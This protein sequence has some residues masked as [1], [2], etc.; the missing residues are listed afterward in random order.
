MVQDFHFQCTVVEKYISTH[1][2]VTDT[3]YN[4]ATN[5]LA[6]HSNDTSKDKLSIIQNWGSIIVIQVHAK[7][8]KRVH[9]YMLIT[10]K[11]KK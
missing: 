10:L 5:K 6:F 3:S 8:K 4:Q 1:V 11:H 2:H 9:L 7:L